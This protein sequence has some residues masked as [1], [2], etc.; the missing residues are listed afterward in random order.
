MK[1]ATLA[2]LGLATLL[3]TAACHKTAPVASKPA[4]TTPVA[5]APAERQAAPMQQRQD[6]APAHPA[7]HSD[8]G[9]AAR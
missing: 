3:S 4:D 7:A 9:R 2:M 6:N 5:S 1:H 8:P